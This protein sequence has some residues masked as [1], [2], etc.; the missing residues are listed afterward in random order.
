[1]QAGVLVP[2]I[3][4][5][6]VHPVIDHAPDLL[7]GPHAALLTVAPPAQTLK[8]IYVFAAAALRHRPDVVRFEQKVVTQSIAKAVQKVS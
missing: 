5:Q 1:M 2:V 8:I 4:V 3:R 6:T 7:V